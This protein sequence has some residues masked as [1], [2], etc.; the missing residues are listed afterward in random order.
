M[1]K[2]SQELRHSTKNSLKLVG[3]YLGE[4]I[5]L[6]CSMAIWPRH[7]DRFERQYD[8]S[9]SKDHI[10]GVDLIDTIHKRFHVFLH[11]CNTVDIEDIDSV[12]LVEFRSL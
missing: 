6:R 10:F 8:K 3:D 7:I 2:T 1:V 9:F 11:S 4:D 12:N 5:P